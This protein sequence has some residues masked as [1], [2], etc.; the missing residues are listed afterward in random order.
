MS[1]ADFDPIAVIERAYD[2]DLSDRDWLTRVMEAAAPAFDS[3]LGVSGALWQL[4]VHGGD[5]T[6]V[7]VS[8]RPELVALAP[9]V[10]G[11]IGSAAPRYYTHVPSFGQASAL[12]DDPIVAQI[13]ARCSAALGQE[14]KDIVGIRVGDGGRSG[15]VITSFAA[16]RPRY[17]DA[18]RRRFARLALHV[19]AGLRLRA[20]AASGL[21]QSADAV[22]DVRGRALH[23]QDS[24]K[25][26]A[27]RKALASAVHAIERARGAL[28]KRAPD[29]AIE[30]WRALVAGRWTVVDWVD[31][32]GRRLMVAHSNAVDSGDPRTLSAR[33]RD[34]AEFLVHGRSNAEISYALGLASGTV[35]RIVRSVLR[36]LGRAR[37]SDLASLFGAPEL[38]SAPLSGDPTLLVVDGVLRNDA[39]WARLAPAER[40]VVESALAGASNRQIAHDRRRAESTIANQL[41]TVYARFCVRGRSELAALLGP[42]RGA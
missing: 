23:T 7:D 30:L 42:S 11:Q 25:P 12:G 34:V 8:T 38:R 35:N 16:T 10:Y 33:E 27:A 5:V 19:G 4:P 29:E 41:A 36:K 32:D 20:R 24:A 9:M 18:D 3:G 14:L 2:L 15:V 28:R 22:L 40:E 17:T 39:L 6:A 26:A 31:S 37:R 21:W 1:R 13:L